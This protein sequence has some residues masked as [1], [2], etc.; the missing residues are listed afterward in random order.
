MIIEKLIVLMFCFNAIRTSNGEQ[1]TSE[2]DKP[3]I[4]SDSTV[5]A[6][7]GKR[8]SLKC[9]VHNL[10]NY[11]IAWYFNGMLLS[12]NAIRIKSDQ[13]YSVENPSTNLWVLNI[14]PVDLSNDGEYS[15]QLTNGIKNTVYLR[16]GG[17]QF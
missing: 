11:K 13:R 7:L 8:V 6:V 2:L 4:E 9:L 16:V 12:L 10:K 15:C 5:N 14:E 1:V 3:F 17:M